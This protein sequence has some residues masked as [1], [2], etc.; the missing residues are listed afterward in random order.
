MRRTNSGALR[1]PSTGHAGG[2]EQEV[3]RRHAPEETSTPQRTLSRVTVVP[4]FMSRPLMHGASEVEL[5]VKRIG[6]LRAAVPIE[7]RSLGKRTLAES[8]AEVLL[9]DARRS[10]PSVVYRAIVRARNGG[11]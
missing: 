11:W 9:L 3:Q 8:D 7:A 10:R 1:R 6:T 4:V 2:A 5:M